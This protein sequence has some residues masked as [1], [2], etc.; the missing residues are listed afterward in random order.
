MLYLKI[1]DGSPVDHPVFADNL[2]MVFGCIPDEYAPFIRTNQPV[3]GMYEVWDTDACQYEQVDGNWTDKWPRR[4]MTEEERSEKEIAVMASLI[5]IKDHLIS[6]AVEGAEKASTP[7]GKSH[8]LD[9][10]E[11]VKAIEISADEGFNFP[12]P[13]LVLEDGRVIMPTYSS[14]SAP[15]VI[16]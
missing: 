13:P 4:P 15:D 9:Y 7:E 12:N 1:V 8:C 2:H 6:L 10:I 16:G 3:L 14:G 5:N 11:M